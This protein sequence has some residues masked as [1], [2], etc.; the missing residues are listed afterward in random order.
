MLIGIA[1]AGY[2]FPKSQQHPASTQTTPTSPI[3]QPAQA[4]PK[5]YQGYQ[6]INLRDFSGGTLSGLATRSIIPGNPSLY[7][8][9]NLPESG[10]G[11]LYQ[12]WLLKNAN[13]YLLLG[14][15]SRNDTESYSSVY[16]TK[17]PSFSS[18]NDVQ[19]NKIIVTLEIADDNQMETK[20]LEGTFTQ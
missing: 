2:F 19:Y 4:P 6:T 8:S 3:Q 16:F 13:D 1:I 10:E 12:T 20:V 7:L 5:N 17:S 18:F 14:R 11:Q 9:A 15:V